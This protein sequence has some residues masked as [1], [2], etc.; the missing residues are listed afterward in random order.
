MKRKPGVFLSRAVGLVI[1]LTL[2]FSLYLFAA[3]SMES[4][5]FAFEDGTN[6]GFFVDEGRL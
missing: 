6:M 1:A 5:R 3:D 2:C 4:K